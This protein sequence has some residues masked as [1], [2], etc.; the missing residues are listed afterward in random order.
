M[1]ISFFISIGLGFVLFEFGLFGE[2]KSGF[3]L[4]T[5][6]MVVVV[7]GTLTAAFV[8][9]P[10]GKLVRIIHGSFRMMVFG[11]NS[12]PDYVKKLI[13]SVLEVSNGSK[14]DRNLLMSVKAPHPFL[15]EG[16]QL[17]GDGL[18]SEEELREVM[19]R[20]AQTFSRVYLEDSKILESLSKF[21]P[22]F[23][24]L[25]AVTGMIGMM[26]QLGGGT[27][28]IGKSMATAL[29]ATFWGIAMANL[30]LL[31]LSDYYKYLAEADLY[32][33]K[34]IIEAVVLIKRKESL[35]IIEEKLNSY[36][37]PKKRI[38]GAVGASGISSGSIKKAA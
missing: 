29:V 34:I 7:L 22:A 11:K 30:V 32:I 16:L 36:L 9:V 18:L 20:R 19:S 38:S 3:F 2:T 37:P 6:A 23:G 35:P 28:T 10:I 14:T 4:N 33:R 25:G 24:L 26:G 27:E 1:N 31:P 8:S 15:T 13:Q 17:I 12:D 21:P 5:H